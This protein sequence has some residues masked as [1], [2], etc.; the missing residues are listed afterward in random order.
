MSARSLLISEASPS[1][2]EEFILVRTEQASRAVITS[3]TDEEKR[4]RFMHSLLSLVDPNIAKLVIANPQLRHAIKIAF[5]S[6]DDNPDYKE[7]YECLE[8]LGDKFV[9]L[10]ITQIARWDN[11][12]QGTGVVQRFASKNN[13]HNLSDALNLFD[14]LSPETR[15]LENA[16]VEKKRRIDIHESLFGLLHKISHEILFGND[17]SFTIVRLNPA[18]MLKV[19]SFP[20]D[21]MSALLDSLKTDVTTVTES[22]KITLIHILKSIGYD[23]SSSNM[24]IK[25][26]VVN[27]KRVLTIRF[28]KNVVDDLNSMRAPGKLTFAEIGNQKVIGEYIE[29]GFNELSTEEDTLNDIW[30]KAG[31]V[32]MQSRMDIFDMKA[33]IAGVVSDMPQVLK[34]KGLFAAAL[35]CKM[36]LRYNQTVVT[37]ETIEFAGRQL[38]ANMQLWARFKKGRDS[39]ALDMLFNVS[40]LVGLKITSCASVQLAAV[41][42]KRLDGYLKGN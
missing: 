12:C 29:F 7:N 19:L 42:A 33:F 26:D 16:S 11:P 14:L 10:L 4:I 36:G 27:G 1:S 34:I 8:F 15:A 28:N 25:S 41:L 5:A 23:P 17:D 32:E 40:Q 31:M 38:P 21:L 22:R 18:L 35:C 39:P 9:N 20:R 13:Q 3:G 30:E 6:K 24:C 2:I 37:T